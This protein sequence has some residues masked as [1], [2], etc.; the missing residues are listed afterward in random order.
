MPRVRNRMSLFAV[1]LVIG[2]AALA[3]LWLLGGERVSFDSD[4]AIVGLMAR[5]INQGKPIPTFFYGQ[6]YMGSLDALLVAGSFRFLGES[7]MAM[8]AVQVALALVTLCL[9]YRLA[10]GNQRQPP[11]RLAGVALAGRPHAPDWTLHHR[12]LGRLQ[13]GTAL[14]DAD[15]AVELADRHR[16]AR[17]SLALGSARPGRRAGLVDSR[18]DRHGLPGCRGPGTAHAVLAT[19]APG[20]A[21]RCSWS[22]SLQAARPGGPITCATTG[23]Q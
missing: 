3:R 5:H 15:A 2:M 17:R 7:V 6:A 11:C 22:R 23:R 4:E 9:V 8:R 1:A 18:S 14:R 21:M 16:A 12:G 10:G 13:R 19:P 20:A